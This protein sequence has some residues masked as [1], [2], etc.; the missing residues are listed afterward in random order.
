MMSSQYF[1][2][3]TSSD[4]MTCGKQIFSSRRCSTTIQTLLK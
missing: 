2:S 4:F 1:D 3:S